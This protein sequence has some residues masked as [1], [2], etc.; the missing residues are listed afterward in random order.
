MSFYQLVIYSISDFFS[1]LC[2][3]IFT[4]K[5]FAWPGTIALLAVLLCVDLFLECIRY[6]LYLYGYAQRYLIFVRAAFGVTMEYILSEHRDSR[7]LFTILM[8]GSY[9]MFG[10]V[11]AKILY[12]VDIKLAATVFVELVVDVVILTF[13]VVCLLPSY[14][15]LQ[16][17]Y[18]REWGAFSLLLSMFFVCEYLIYACLKH[19]NVTFIQTVIPMGHLIILYLLMTLAFRMFDRVNR[20][21]KELQEKRILEAS[22]EALRHDVEEIRNAEQRIATYNHDSRHFVRIISGMMA[23]GDYCGVSQALEQVQKH[24]ED[25]NTHY[26]CENRPLD[27][28]VAYYV[29]LARER[30]VLINVRMDKMRRLSQEDWELAV[31]LGGLL[32]VAI[33]EAVNVKEPSQRRVEFKAREIGQQI[34]FMVNNTFRGVNSSV[35]EQK[36]EQGLSVQSAS[37][38]ARRRSGSIDYGVDDDLFYVRLLI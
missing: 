19:P 10:D 35:P 24:V 31:V 17:V 29:Q 34:L 12:Y 38:F 22:M 33:G 9:S 21:E 1:V 7:A 30:D 23:E 28:V 27:G 2:A 18:R 32:D 16:M 5:R 3:A 37:S 26:Y 15:R 20:E 25:R 6:E 4:K 36:Q 11:I 13:M 14:R 8:A